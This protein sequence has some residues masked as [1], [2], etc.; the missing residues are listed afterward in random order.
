MNMSAAPRRPARSERP[1]KCSRPL[2]SRAVSKS[3]SSKSPAGKLLRARNLPWALLLQAGTLVGSR[4]KS[5]SAKDRAR[6]TA[7][8]RESGGRVGTL[9]AKQRGELRELVGKL[10]L[11]GLGGDLLPLVR[12][13]R[14]RGK[15]G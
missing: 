3:E 15:R 4:W 2:P 12:G 7:L 6:L 1:E 14:K 10:D 5:L 11:K 13:G 8:L 9:S